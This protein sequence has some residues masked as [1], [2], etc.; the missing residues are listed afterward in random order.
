VVMYREFGAGLAQALGKPCLFAPMGIR[1]TTGFVR[2]LGKLLGTDE[3]V[4][5]FI[6]REKRS[7]LQPVWD[8][9]RGPQG[10]WFPTTEFAV[11]AGRTYAEGLV[12]FLGDE[13]GMR[14]AFATGHPI[15]PG[16]LDNMAVREWLHK[17]QPG[18]VFGSLNEKIY[19]AEAGARA[20]HFIP[21]GFPIPIVRRALGTPFMGYSGAVYVV[22]EMV[23]RFYESVFNFLPIDMVKQAAPAEPPGPPA[24]G[25]AP[26]AGGLM[27]SDAARARMEAHL[28][29]IPW[30][31][32][33]SATREL[34]AQVESYAIRQRVAEVTPDVVERALASS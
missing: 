12:K 30:L 13:L 10:D 29:G 26:S 16:E 5:A 31:S 34:R 1:E 17:K 9:W 14:P 3:Q 24:A 25:P 32:R 18:F 27:W 21:A 28:E 2:E 33:I 19:L 7:T 23:N 6:E 11:V 20:T 4:E 15:R 8:L 22:Q